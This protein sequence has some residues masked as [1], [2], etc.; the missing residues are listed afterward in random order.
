M[1]RGIAGLARLTQPLLSQL[2]Q[3][4]CVRTYPLSVQVFLTDSYLVLVME[5][6]AGADLFRLV[7]RAKGLA[8]GEARWFFQQIMFAVDYSHKM[9][10]RCCC[11]LSPIRVVSVP[12]WV[13]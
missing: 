5:Y 13:V 1:L 7:S 9:V 3:A 12:C 4:P 6:A 8:E 11:C 10:R 2:T